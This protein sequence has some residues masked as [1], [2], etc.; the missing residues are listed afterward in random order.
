M[1]SITLYLGVLYCA[2]NEARVRRFLIIDT[3]LC[4]W[5]FANYK[6]LMQADAEGYYDAS[7]LVAWS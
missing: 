5:L 2:R 7:G 1:C 4:E 3:L 6:G